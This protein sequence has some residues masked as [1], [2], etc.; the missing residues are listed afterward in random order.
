MLVVE[1]DA[2]IRRAYSVQKK[3]I[4]EICRE[5]RT[6][7]KVVRNV[8]RSEA[9]EFRYQRETQPLPR[10]GPYQSGLDGL[11]AVNNSK[12]RCERLTL[13][14]VFE[15]LRARGYEAGYDAAPRH[16]RHLRQWVHR[17]PPRA[18]KPASRSPRAS[19]VPLMDYRH[20]PQP[21][22]SDGRHP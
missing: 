8:L 11:L 5:L 20:K 4:K 9:T 16:A 21:T 17:H 7:R 2:K 18:A 10:I 22:R 13:I 6:S 12:P 1:T 15:K 14:R 3:P 19:R